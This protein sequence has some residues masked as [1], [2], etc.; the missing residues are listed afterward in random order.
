MSQVPNL[1]TPEGRE[2]G[3]RHSAHVH[4]IVKCSCGAI[5]LQC[6]CMMLNK[7]VRIV[8]NGC[9][10]CKAKSAATPP[11]AQEGE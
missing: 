5:I 6:R 9:E 8:K 11:P 10:K 1:P 3:A 7:P 2:A 4:E